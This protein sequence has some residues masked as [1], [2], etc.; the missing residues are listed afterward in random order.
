MKNKLKSIAPQDYIS[1][2]DILKWGNNILQTLLQD[3]A[4]GRNIFWATDDYLAEGEG[5]G[6]YDEITIDRITGFHNNLIMPRYAKTK[7]DQR[8]RSKDKAEVFT[9]SWI[10]NAQNNLIDSKWFGLTE[11]PFNTMSSDHTE[12]FVKEDP[13]EFTGKKKWQDYVRSIRM[14]MTCGEAPYLCSRFD[15]I[16]G[17]FFSDL[18]QRIGIIDRKL[19]VVTENTHEQPSDQRAMWVRWAMAAYQSTYGYEWQG[20]N[21]YKARKA[22]LLTYRDYFFDRWGEYPNGN[23]L[24]RI[25]EI[26]SWN[27]WQ[28]DG[29]SFCVPSKDKDN[30]AETCLIAEWDMNNKKP[31]ILNTIEYKS[32]IS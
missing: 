5:Y 1:E 16:T 17:K 10:C 6:F 7:S 3:H 27:I 4:T 20:D 13:I 22:L 24:R 31:I 23:L 15:A 21:L 29:L 25:A 11:S 9:P 12:W 26:I 14:E 8:N 2:N 19:R 30:L 32:I 28:M 18:Y